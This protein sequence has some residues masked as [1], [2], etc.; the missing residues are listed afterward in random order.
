MFFIVLNIGYKGGSPKPK[1]VL[2]QK[3]KGTSKGNSVPFNELFFGLRVA[4]EN[5]NLRNGYVCNCVIG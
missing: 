3:E 1:K 2:G 4:T 5:H